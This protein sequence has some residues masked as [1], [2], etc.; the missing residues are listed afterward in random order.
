MCFDVG[1]SSERVN[2]YK[3]YKSDTDN[4]SGRFGIKNLRD[5]MT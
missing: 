2:V 4:F 3:N 1:A 5:S